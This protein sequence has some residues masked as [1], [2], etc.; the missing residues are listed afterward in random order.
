MLAA[1]CAALRLQ[2]LACAVRQRQPRAAP[3]LLAASTQRAPP[4]HRCWTGF[5]RRAP[6]RSFQARSSG[7]GDAKGS[8]DGGDKK[9]EL[10]KTLLG[11]PWVRRRAAR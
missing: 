5:V 11:T 6:Q 9:E 10:N 3:F 8:K 1:R 7:D 2:P 4:S